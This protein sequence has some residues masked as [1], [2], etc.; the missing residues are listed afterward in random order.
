MELIWDKENP[1]PICAEMG[2]TVRACVLFLKLIRVVYQKFKYNTVLAKTDVLSTHIR[3]HS[4]G[5][6]QCIIESTRRIF[7]HKFFNAIFSELVDWILLLMKIW[8]VLHQSGIVMPL[9]KITTGWCKKNYIFM[10]IS[11]RINLPLLHRCMIIMMTHLR[12]HIGLH[13]AHK[14][15]HLLS[16]FS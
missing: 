8:I 5:C 4:N 16:Q 11:K 9:C 14:K 10:L 7:M 13:I 2:T 12:I 3:L 1:V 15:K 6:D